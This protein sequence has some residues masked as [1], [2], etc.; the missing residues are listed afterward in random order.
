M[1][2]CLLIIIDPL[3]DYNLSLSLYIYIYIC[4]KLFE[5]MYVRFT[6][7]KENEAHRKS[8]KGGAFRLNM[9]PKQLFDDNP[10]RSDRALPPVKRDGSSKQDVK[11]FKPSSPGKLV[12]WSCSYFNF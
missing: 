8:L 3:I 6:F 7:Q 9:A 1:S 5:T 2:I 10:Y 4:E 11:P 12:S